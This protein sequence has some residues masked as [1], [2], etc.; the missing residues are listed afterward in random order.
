MSPQELPS[1]DNAADQAPI[2]EP[3]V[4]QSLDL[5]PAEKEEVVTIAVQQSVRTIKVPCSVGAEGYLRRRVDL[6]LDSQQALVLKQVLM[7]L[8]STDAKLK[9]GRYVNSHGSA[10]QWLLE[11]T[12]HA[13][14]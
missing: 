5:E 7:G 10:L 8:E 4:A 14:K 6:R 3:V 2:P 13:G 12:N 9:N 1:I 11:T